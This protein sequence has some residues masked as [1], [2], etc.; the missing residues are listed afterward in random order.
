MFFKV[1]LI[2]FQLMRAFK[3]YI[4]LVEGRSEKRA[5]LLLG[6]QILFD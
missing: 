4:L 1:Y 2:C 5:L 6:C 3:R